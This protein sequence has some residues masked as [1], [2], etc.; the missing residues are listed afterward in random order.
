VRGNMVLVEKGGQLKAGGSR[1]EFWAQLRSSCISRRRREIFYYCCQQIAFDPHGFNF[2]PNSSSS[3]SSCFL[4]TGHHPTPCKFSC[5]PSDELFGTY[6][7]CARVLK[8]NNAIGN[9]IFFWHTQK[10]PLKQSHNN[11][12][13]HKRTHT[14]THRHKSTHTLH[15][16]IMSR[17][18]CTSCN[19]RAR[20]LNPLQSSNK[21]GRSACSPWL[22]A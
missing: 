15:T 6:D 14:H 13:S 12:R 18:S 5:A 19:T 1:R 11:T 10:Q 9:N 16:N 7:Y 22:S 4:L 2:H 8:G 21:L 17:V 3:C 20:S